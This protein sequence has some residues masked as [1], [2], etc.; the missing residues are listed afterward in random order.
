MRIAKRMPVK[1]LAAT[2]L[3]MTGA[4][5]LSRDSLRARYHLSGLRHAEQQMF[6]PQPSTFRQ[7]AV[8]FLF[9]RPSWEGW[10]AI[11]SRHEDALIR[12][13][14]FD[15][16]E[17]PLTNQHLTAVQ[18]LT[19]AQL[20]FDSQFSSVTVVTNGQRLGGTTVASNS[21]VEIIAPTAEMNHWRT[22]VLELD[23][24]RL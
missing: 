6:A 13:G 12:M 2:L 19:N 22:L 18:L 20:R 3:L 9:R 8:A 14:Y 1:F 11:R 16:R 7:Q 10:A 15:R 21:S 23:G 5:W 4:L 24:G 17:F